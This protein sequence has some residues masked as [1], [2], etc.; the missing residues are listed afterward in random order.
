M[1]ST[2]QLLVVVNT[3]LVRFGLRIDTGTE[4]TMM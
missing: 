1:I 3:Y 4:R 2:G